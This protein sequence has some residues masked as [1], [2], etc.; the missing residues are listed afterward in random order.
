MSKKI[1]EGDLMAALRAALPQPP[2]E[3][4]ITVLKWRLRFNI[5]RNA[6]RDEINRLARANKIA[7]CGKR[8]ENGREVSA[9]REVV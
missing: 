9:W 2:A 5:T 8:Y 4:E 1:T 7:E 6:A 3:D